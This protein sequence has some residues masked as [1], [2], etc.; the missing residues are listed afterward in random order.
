MNVFQSS[1]N[2][3]KHKWSCKRTLKTHEKMCVLLK[4]IL[5]EVE[6]RKEMLNDSG[7]EKYGVKK[8]KA[9]YIPA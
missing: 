3:F 8:V 1:R 9:S 2:I 5:E 7:K 6:H 4:A